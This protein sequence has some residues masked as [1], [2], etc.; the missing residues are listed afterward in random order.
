MTQEEPLGER[1]RTL[2]PFARHFGIN[3]LNIGRGHATLEGFDRWGQPPLEPESSDARRERK[4]AKAKKYRERPSVHEA[5]VRRLIA[6]RRRAPTRS[7]ALAATWRDA[8]AARGV[9]VAYV[10][11]PAT[12][13][14]SFPAEVPNE[15][16]LRVFDFNDPKKYPH[17]YEITFHYDTIHLT[18]PGAQSFSRELADAL[19]AA[20]DEVEAH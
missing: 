19:D 13:N 14:S 17:L 8:A 5:R 11:G 15:P 18:E 10:I 9:E 4:A 2:W 20:M 3:A 1:L 7:N 6:D 16:D 12:G